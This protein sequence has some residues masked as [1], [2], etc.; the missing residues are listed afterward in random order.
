MATPTTIYVKDSAADEWRTIS[1]FTSWRHGIIPVTG[2]PYRNT[3]WSVGKLSGGVTDNTST[4]FDSVPAVL[5]AVSPAATAAAAVIQLTGT[6]PDEMI[7]VPQRQWLRKEFV[8]IYAFNNETIPSAG[9]TFAVSS[10]TSGVITLP[11][12]SGLSTGDFIELTSGTITNVTTHTLYVVQV[13]STTTYSLRDFSTGALIN[14]GTAASAVL[15]LVTP[16]TLLSG[17][18]EFVFYSN[19]PAFSIADPR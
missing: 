8:R 13:L 15:T 2:P 9:Q 4:I 3:G 12:G 1:G 5:N 18:F 16:A 6:A 19:N 17:Q 14:A 10:S 7:G 11:S